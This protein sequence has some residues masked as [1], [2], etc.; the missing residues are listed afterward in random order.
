MARTKTMALIAAGTMALG[1]RLPAQDITV[2]SRTQPGAAQVT[3][4][5]LC[6][7]RF[8]IKNDGSQPV[9]LQYGLHDGPQLTGI[10]VQPGESIELSSRSNT[11]VELWKDGTRIATAARDQRSCANMT[12]AN[13]NGA[14]LNGG[15]GV[16]VTQP[17]LVTTATGPT[18]VYSAYPYYWDPYYGP[19]APAPAFGFGVRVV[20]PFGG[21][22]FVNRPFIVARFGRRR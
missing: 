8:V 15:G 11:S 21:P 4:G 22:V 10:T 19:W 2:T 7:D 12:S 16:T 18:Y 20:R 5:Y 3:F 1:A 9:N 14:N 13:L 6:D 17:V